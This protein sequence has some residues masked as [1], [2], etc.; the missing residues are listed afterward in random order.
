LGST[1][2]VPSS[3]SFVYPTYYVF[4]A[5]SSTPP[6]VTTLVNGNVPASG[7]TAN[8]SGGKVLSTTINNSGVDPQALWFCVRSSA[9]QPTTFQTGAS[10]AL[11]SSYIV[12]NA[13]TVALYPN[14][15]PSGWTTNE[16]YS[17]YAITLQPGNTYVSIA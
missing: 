13:N 16:N 3:V 7:V 17:C 10:A 15:L 4:T 5:D 2:T 11:L 14:P 6:I 8:N 9:S 1:A 12:G